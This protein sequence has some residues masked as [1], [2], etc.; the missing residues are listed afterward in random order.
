MERHAPPS[1]GG[2]DVSKPLLDGTHRRKGT[3]FLCGIIATITEIPG[4]SLELVTSG[5]NSLGD[6]TRG[7][8][9]WHGHRSELWAYIAGRATPYVA[10]VYTAVDALKDYF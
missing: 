2:F 6:F 1:V 7:S 4:K 3:K 5:K 8:D 9:K 10:A